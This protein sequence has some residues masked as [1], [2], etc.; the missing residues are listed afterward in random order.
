MEIKTRDV[1]LIDLTGRS[2]VIFLTTVIVVPTRMGR[3]NM[4]TLLNRLQK[5]GVASRAE[6]AKSLGMSQPTAGRIAD[7]LLELGVLEEVGADAAEPAGSEPSRSQAGRLGRPGR[8]LRLD[9]TRPRFLAI[10]LEITETR[11]AL[12]PVGFKG[13]DNWTVHVPTPNSDKKLVEQ[14]RA[15]AEKMPQKDFWGVLVSVP[16]IVDETSSKVLFSPNLHWTEQLNL[17]EHIQKV[18]DAPVVLVQEERA[19]ALGHQSVEPVGE[20]FML[21]DFGEGVGGAVIQEGKLFANP[22]PISGELGHT[23]VLGNRRLCGCGAIGCMESLVSTRGL[24]QSFAESRGE[25][26][27]TWPALT[28]HI[29]KEGV[30]PWLA[31]ALDAA[32]MAIAGALNVL[33]LRRVVI[34]GSLTELPETVAKYLSDAIVRGALWARFG[35]VK[36]ETACRRRMAGLVAT[37]IDRLVISMA[38]SHGGIG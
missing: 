31:Q 13:E 16:G 23:P 10:E 5:V 24:L 30:T 6:L 25:T 2:I 22:L 32:A 1:R 28:Q 18:W 33:G 3:L 21:V 7:E 37:G 4:R 12:M 11:F 29:E 20:D 8:L 14:L 34:T 27:S 35:R 26:R 9:S 38:E 36:C 15:A 19:L 17:A